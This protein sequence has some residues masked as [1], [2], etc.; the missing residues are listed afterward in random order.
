MNIGYF[1]TLENSSIADTQRQVFY[2][3]V[4]TPIITQRLEM[5]WISPVLFSIL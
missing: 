1:D 2:G 5:P 3:F 4:T